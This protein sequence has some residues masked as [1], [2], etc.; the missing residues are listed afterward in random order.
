M[1]YGEGGE[2]GNSSVIQENLFRNKGKMSERIKGIKPE[3]KWWK[4][5]SIYKEVQA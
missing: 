1:Q 2:T 3:R 5:C 4:K